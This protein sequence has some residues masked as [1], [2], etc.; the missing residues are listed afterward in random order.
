MRVLSLCLVLLLA[1]CS[2]SSLVVEGS[3]EPGGLFF[4]DPQHGWVVGRQHDKDSVFIAATEDGGKTWTTTSMERQGTLTG[5]IFT[6]PE[7]GRAFGSHA[8]A[9]STSDGGRRWKKESARGDCADYSI[10]DGLGCLVLNSTGYS[11]KRGIFCFEGDDF[12]KGIFRSKARNG[13]IFHGRSAHVIDADTVWVAGD[14][15]IYLSRDRGHRWKVVEL[16][17]TLERDTV[18]AGARAAY[19][20]SAETGWLALANGTLLRVSEAGKTRVPVAG[21]GVE[22]RAAYELHFFDERRG[23]MLAAPDRGDAAVLVTRDGGENWTV[24]K[25]FSDGRWTQMFVLDENHA[26][27]AGRAQDGVRIQLVSPF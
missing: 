1:G 13:R 24:K 16:E 26:W 11:R 12:E 18:V 14:T 17:E 23:V 20:E 5:I 9:Y 2:G 15:A 27:V 25:E 19:F 7:N 4:L 6:D 8:T 21:N 10:K 22:G 3:A